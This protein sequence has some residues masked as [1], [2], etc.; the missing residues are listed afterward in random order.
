MEW[1]VI[2]QDSLVVDK[3]SSTSKSIHFHSPSFDAGCIKMGMIFDVDDTSALRLPGAI[4][5]NAFQI[6]VSAIRVSRPTNI[7]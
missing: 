6:N 2:P 3:G 1:V 5:V 4:C 7:Q